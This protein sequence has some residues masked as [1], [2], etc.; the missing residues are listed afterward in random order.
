MAK[1]QRRASKQSS[2]LAQAGGTL[3]LCLF[4]LPFAGV[5]LFMLGWTVRDVWEHRQ[6]QSWQA[7]PATLLQAELKTTRGDKGRITYRATARYRYD[8]AGKTYES[9]RVALH[10]SGDNFGDY[11]EERGKELKQLKRTGQP[12][13]AYVN[14]HDPSQAILFRDLRPLMIMVKSM[15]GL[16]FGGVGFALLAGGLLS[17]V[18]GRRESKRRQEF[19]DEP[20]RWQEKWQARRLRST[21]KHAWSGFAFAALWNLIGWTVFIMAASSGDTEWP[22]LL[23]V[24]IFP[25][26]GVAMAGWAAYVWLQRWKWGVSELE[27]A[28]F[29]GVL[30]GPLAGVI[31]VP[32]AVEAKE[33]IVVRLAC[34]RAEQRGKHKTNVTLWDCEHTIVRQLTTP[35]RLQTLIPAKFVIPHDL[36][37]SS[38]DDVTWRLSASAATE[39]IDFHVEFDVPVFE[40][41]ASSSTPAEA[42]LDDG[43]L[44]APVS[45]RMIAS[46]VRARIEEDAPDRKTLL[47]PIARHLGLTTFLTLFSVGWIAVCIGLWFTDAPRLFPIVSGLF[48]LLFIPIM[49][50]IALESVRL[51]FGRHG[52]RVS[53]RIAGFGRDRSFAPQEIV[54]VS[55]AKS[56]MTY[57][58]TTYWNVE[59]HDRQGKRHKLATAIPQRQQAERLAA[60]IAAM[61]GLSETR[62]SSEASRM[63]LES[64]LP[65]D[66]RGG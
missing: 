59:L 5:G 3:F 26:I 45:L 57:G 14:P 47:F 6:F 18:E 53:R 1:K 66:L 9:E 49:M 20:W 19:P 60:E 10:G 62:K 2:P 43:T 46:G 29:P 40:T 34:V 38:A 48:A 30:G 22:I 55:A 21:V 4:A 51:Q 41:E 27:L 11:Q 16:A 37:D 15:F 17:L 12:V 61:V 13:T 63:R 23:L 42:A 25:L 31:T 56:G 64:E 7:T 58:E 36:P 50:A 32:R 65:A 54:D 28:T 52:V 24:A 33:G 39:G 8:F 44:D 35:D